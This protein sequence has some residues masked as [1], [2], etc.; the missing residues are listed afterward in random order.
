MRKLV[1]ACAAGL[2]MTPSI[3]LAQSGA[4]PHKSLDLP[5]EGD[6]SPE[7]TDM[8]SAEQM[9]QFYPKL[10]QSLWLKGR[11]R[12][13][14][15]TTTVGT[16]ESC[17]VGAERPAGMG[18][19]D[20]ALLLVPYFHY[21]PKL[22][23]GNPVGGDDVSLNIIF[24]LPPSAT[25]PAP[26]PQRPPPSPHALELARGL[27]EAQNV[28]A[29]FADQVKQSV[30]AFK[31]QLESQTPEGQISTPQ[32]Q[33]AIQAF[34]ES[35]EAAAPAYIDQ[36]ADLYARTYTESELTQILAFWRSPA[37]QA[38]ATHQADINTGERRLQAHSWEDIS[39][40]ARDRLC[41]K[42]DCM[43]DQAPAKPAQK[44]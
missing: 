28:T 18:F 4:A 20:A 15:R 10:A 33:L 40:G 39:V 23:H 26:A 43:D 22:S 31:A 3:A 2:A 17:H 14:C 30:N 1:L 6:F 41:A 9:S 5:I 8:P 37:G 32:G 36:I 13:D 24:Q 42:I 16:L 44:P 7:W 29:H 19:G 34:R 35:M 21:K 11:A 27:L 25:P 12:L 38:F